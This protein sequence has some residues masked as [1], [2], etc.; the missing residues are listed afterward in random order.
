MINMGRIHRK[1]GKFLMISSNL[2]KSNDESM[3]EIVRKWY[4]MKEN[5]NTIPRNQKSSNL[6]FIRG[7][8]ED[9]SEV[10]F[11]KS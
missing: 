8:I 10:I 4:I 1:L 2:I 5:F 9:R 3:I 7:E 6:T 11:P